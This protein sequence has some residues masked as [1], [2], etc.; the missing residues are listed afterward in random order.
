MN[1]YKNMTVMQKILVSKPTILRGNSELAFSN[2]ITLS[3]RES[4]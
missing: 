1:E 4:V 3:E 2:I